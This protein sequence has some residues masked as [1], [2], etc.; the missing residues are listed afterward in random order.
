MNTITEQQRRQSIEQSQLVGYWAKTKG[1][2]QKDLLEH[3]QIDDAILL[4]QI[5]DE[6]WSKFNLSE[7]G[8]WSG[9]WNSVY[10]KRNRL[11]K[12]AYK[13]LEQIIITATTRHETQRQLIK[14]LK[15]NPY[16]KP[17][18]YMTAKTE[19]LTQTVPW[20]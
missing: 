14:A 16:A 5:R 9:Y 6:M 10:F 12:K 20:E 19:G 2:T 18:A 4:I 7:R 17:S 11:K 8:C 15:Q 3:P 1:L 13:K